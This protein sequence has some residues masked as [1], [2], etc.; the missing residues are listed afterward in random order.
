VPGEAGEDGIGLEPPITV[1]KPGRWE[2]LRGAVVRLNESATWATRRTAERLREYWSGLSHRKRHFAEGILVGLLIE[3]L[4]AQTGGFAVLVGIRNAA[5][6]TVLRNHAWIE[7]LSTE[8]VAPRLS[9]IDV[10]EASWRDP[11]WGEPYRA[12]RHRLA[13]LVTYAFDHG[14]RL[15]V[16]DVLVETSAQDA[17]AP[18]NQALASA[19][20][21]LKPGQSVILSRSIRRPLQEIDDPVARVAPFLPDSPFD[22]LKT[23][24]TIIEALPEFHIDRDAQVRS[25]TL[26]HSVCI[27]DFPGAVFGRWR[28][29]PSIQL[30]A[31][32]QTQTFPP[33]R[34]AGGFGR[35]AT[36][37][38]GAI[39]GLTTTEAA[40]R[41]MRNWIAR[42][43]PFEHSRAP[44]TDDPHATSPDWRRFE[45]GSRIYYRSAYDP[46]ACRA[47]PIQR[48]SA[49]AI[50]A[51]GQSA[52]AEV[53]CAL[54]DRLARIVIIGQSADAVGDKWATPLGPMPGAYII[55]NAILSLQDPGPIEELPWLVE[56]LLALA[57]IGL[58]AWAFAWFSSVRAIAIVG[59]PLVVTLM[60]LSWVCLKFGVWIDY[61]MPALGIWLH[62]LWG[63]ARALADHG[64]HVKK[65]GDGTEGSI[66]V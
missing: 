28:P 34:R 9:L 17:A 11:T 43:K 2:R 27:P 35:C 6:D 12:P 21:A 44:E 53:P 65:H 63:Q 15:V 30:A 18:G 20:A 42:T 56:G 39:P 19:L 13:Q 10:D 58:V 45:P 37:I 59:L 24:G 26:W 60:L 7:N 51:K 50:L 52:A 1:D 38:S 22:G 41:A 40:D 48:V 62:R 23:P 49:V 57:H 3:L 16:L 61:A 14:A 31:A 5:M 64:N 33:W 36:Q 46:E 55:A 8:D 4:L 47:G 25:W 29:L 32:A 66:G 54:P